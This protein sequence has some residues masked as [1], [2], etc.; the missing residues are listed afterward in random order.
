MI[1]TM[2]LVAII[3]NFWTLVL[4]TQVM[5]NLGHEHYT[6]RKNR[7]LNKKNLY[8]SSILF[9]SLIFVYLFIYLY[10]LLDFRLSTRYVC[11]SPLMLQS[12]TSWWSSTVWFH[13]S[14]SFGS[15]NSQSLSMLIGLTS[16]CFQSNRQRAA[17]DSKRKIYSTVSLLYIS[18]FQAILPDNAMLRHGTKIR[19]DS[20]DIN[21]EK[22]ALMTA[23]HESIY[24]IL[25]Y[26]AKEVS[27]CFCGRPKIEFKR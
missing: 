22:G 7:D 14:S 27:L 21:V 10:L 15:G 5:Y 4:S 11:T 20:I 17:M 23:S 24:K 6:A 1:S 18:I 25:L 12:L 26:K 9:V 19:I 16:A 13:A 3:C 8:L 2:K